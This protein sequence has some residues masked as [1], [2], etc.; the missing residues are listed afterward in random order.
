MRVSLNPLK[1][2][3][4]TVLVIAL[5][6]TCFF[7][8]LQKTDAAFSGFETIVGLPKITIQSDGSVVPQ[9]N[10]IK[11][12]GNTYTLTDNLSHS[13]ALIINCSNIIFDG[14]GHV[15]NGSGL[16]LSDGTS[17][18]YESRG[19]AIENIV[20]VTIKNVEVIG[21]TAFES[22]YI[23]KCSGISLSGISG[24]G[25]YP[26]YMR[27]CNDSIVSQCAFSLRLWGSKGAVIFQNN[28][29]LSYDGSEDCVIYE[30]NIHHDINFS[31]ASPS[32]SN[33]WDNGSVGNYWSDYATKYPNASEIGDSGIANTPY[34]IDGGNVDNY[35][36]I[37]PVSIQQGQESP[38]VDDHQENGF[39]AVILVV[40]VF[41]V[42]IA[43]AIVGLVYKKQRIKV[44]KTSYC[45]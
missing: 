31:L 8:V 16:I 35:P 44:G 32:L 4:G 30:N 10:Y 43:G 29:T 22:I 17:T 13:Y 26:V 18:G 41:S 1:K 12:N 45:G 42:A 33:Q 24:A 7:G 6:L 38:P 20:N 21:F 23:N 15:I 36:L 28:I 19:I 5:F 37:R 40:V 3:A 34:V 2:A 9:T 39:S 27:S 25:D 14:Q 11:Q